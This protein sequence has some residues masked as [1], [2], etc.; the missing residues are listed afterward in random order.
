MYTFLEQNF[1]VFFV[2]EKGT[3]QYT[4]LYSSHRAGEKQLEFCFWYEKDASYTP[5]YTVRHGRKTFLGIFVVSKKGAYYT[6][7]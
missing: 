3:S 6:H 7:F 2:C 1:G 4:H 5:F